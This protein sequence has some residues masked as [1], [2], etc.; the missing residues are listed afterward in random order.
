[1]GAT[2]FAGSALRAALY[3]KVIGNPDLKKFPGREVWV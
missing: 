1:M 2:V 3:Q